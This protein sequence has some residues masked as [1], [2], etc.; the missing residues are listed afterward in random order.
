MSVLVRVAQRMQGLAALM[1]P[2]WQLPLRF[3]VQRL[4]GGLEPEVALLPDLVPRG[5][6]ALDVGANMGVYTYALA[7]LAR[8]VHAIEPQAACCRSI[9]AWAQGAGNVEVHNVGAGAAEGG[10]TLYVP[11]RDGRPVGTRASF[12][13]VE[14]DHREIRVRVLPLDRLGV[15][16]VGFVKIDAEGFERDVLE[17]AREMLLR[18]RPVLLIEIDPAGRSPAEFAATFAL[19]EGL[20]YAG[21]YF[22][23]RGLVRCGADVQSRHPER[24]N[25]IFQPLGA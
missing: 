20:G 17:G 8:Q 7:R 16:D 3:K 11:L 5:R 15:H 13:P 6:V 1:P 14:G 9:E 4:V 24:Y 21:S 23:G 19:L 25:F 18:D 10:F 2:R 22:D 12:I